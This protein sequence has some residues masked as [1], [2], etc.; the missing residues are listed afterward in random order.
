VKRKDEPKEHRVINDF[1]QFYMEGCKNFI[2]LIYSLLACSLYIAQL[3]E[4]NV[5]NDF[6][7]ENF[8]PDEKDIGR[9]RKMLKISGVSLN[10]GKRLAREHNPDQ[11]K[12]ATK[13]LMNAK[14]DLN[15]I[16]IRD[17]NCFAK[18]TT[19]CM[20]MTLIYR[21]LWTIDPEKDFRYFMMA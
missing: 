19:F 2:S 6:K 3:K 21:L 14:T 17:E 11:Y 1:R 9:I 5:N 15:K 4:D 18:M 8:P 16:N 20:H 13:F 10:Q 7:V 12:D